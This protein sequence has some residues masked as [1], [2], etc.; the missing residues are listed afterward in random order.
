MTKK[1]LLTGPTGFLGSALLKRLNNYNVMAVGRSKPDFISEEK[2]NYG[3]IN[4]DTNYNSV[5]NNIDVI[6][7]TAAR[8]HIMN[9]KSKN[10]LSEFRE[11]NTY[12]TLNLAEQAAQKGVKRFIFLSSIKVNGE[13]TDLG[14]T[15]QHSD[16]PNPTDPYSI[17]KYEAEE[18]LKEISRKTGMETVIIR[19]P[20]IYGPGVKGNFS[21]MINWLK[22]GVPLPFKLLHNKR[23]LVSLVNLIDLIITCIEHPDAANQVFLVSDGK[24]ISTAELLQRISIALGKPA[25]LLPV[26]S[27]LIQGAATIVGKK[28]I[29]RR[30]CGSL[31]VDIAHTCKTLGW[32]PPSSME[33]SLKDTVR[34]M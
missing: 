28:E 2:F 3:H 12:G 17:S 9:D 26:P 32:Y 29:S 34:N 23:S 25:L 5:L 30:L 14:K 7:H 1:L 33:N 19:P 8:V 24:D 22:K 13:I 10:P 16:K 27:F 18:G 4:G 20:L 21:S 6:I 31:Q 11:I 15:F